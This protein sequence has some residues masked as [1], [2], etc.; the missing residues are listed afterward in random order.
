MLR[1]QPDAF[2][3]VT[4][5]S[6]VISRAVFTAHIVGTV[7]KAAADAS[8]A[9]RLMTGRRHH[10]HLCGEQGCE[11]HKV[12]RQANPTPSLKIKRAGVLL[13]KLRPMPY[14]YYIVCSCDA[15]SNASSCCRTRSSR[16]GT[17][18]SICCWTL[19]ISSTCLSVSSKK[20]S[21]TES[22]QHR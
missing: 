1:Y 7:A 5:V 18:I 17:H 21:F 11:L 12:S 4:G 6:A 2:I 3:Q 10:L 19:W 9:A 13:L 16:S 14:C 15:R 22:V 20:S 8:A